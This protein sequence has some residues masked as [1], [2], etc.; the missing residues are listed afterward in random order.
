MPLLILIETPSSSSS[1]PWLSAIR[2]C[3]HKSPCLLRI[4]CHKQVP[5]YLHDS[6]ACQ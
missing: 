5:C 4:Y 6:F 1:G 2:R 3:G